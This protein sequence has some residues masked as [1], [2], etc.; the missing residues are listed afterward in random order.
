[1]AGVLS[2][3]PGSGSPPALTPLLLLLTA[4]LSV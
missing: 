2:S 1:M 3:L 4:V